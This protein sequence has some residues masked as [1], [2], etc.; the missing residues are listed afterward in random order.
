VLAKGPE[1]RPT[2]GYAPLT[3]EAR[4]RIVA[5]A[6]TCARHEVALAAV[7]L[8]HSLRDP[9]IASTVVGVSRPERLDELERLARVPVPDELWEALG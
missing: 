5:L 7:A 6:A 8:Q 3:P 4:A 2:Y 1:G 9:R